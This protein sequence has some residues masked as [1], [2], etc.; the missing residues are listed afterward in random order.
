MITENKA[1]VGRKANRIRLFFRMFRLGGTGGLAVFFSQYLRGADPIKV[2]VKEMAVRFLARRHNS[3]L[4]V[5]WEVFGEHECD[6]SLPGRSPRFIIDGGAY[7]GYT[8]AYFAHRYPEARIA[9]IEPDPDNFNLLKL[10][11]GRYDT[12]TLIQGGLWPSAGN[13]VLANSTS[14]SWSVRVREARAQETGSVEGVT[15]PGLMKRTGFDQ[16][17]ILKLDIEGAEEGLFSHET[18]EWLGSVN[19]IIIETHGKKCEETVLKA[20]SKH[21]FIMSRKGE[22]KIFIK[23]GKNR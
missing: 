19:A 11:C 20:V 14:Q 8:T 18:D 6:I 5:L 3:D 21:G 22:K 2:R 23:S 15:I 9:A 1:V 10:N 17:D 12:V 7:A 4:D 16:V 13:L